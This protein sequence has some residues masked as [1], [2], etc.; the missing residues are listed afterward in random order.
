VENVLFKNITYNGQHAAM[1]IIAGYNESRKVQHIVFENL[2]IN[3][4]LISDDMKDKP[5]WYKT[6]DMANIAVGEHVEDVVFRS[7]K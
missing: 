5:S 6:A 3:G 1:S 2:V 7:S 4:Q